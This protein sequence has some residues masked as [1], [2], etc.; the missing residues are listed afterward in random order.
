[1]GR[2]LCQL[3]YTIV[4]YGEKHPGFA[5]KND[6]DVYSLPE[7]GDSN[8]MDTKNGELTANSNDNS[9]VLFIEE[10][11][12][13]AKK[14]AQINT[15]LTES[16]R[17]FSLRDVSKA[18]ERSNSFSIMV[19][20]TEQGNLS[21]TLLS[22]NLFNVH[23][24]FLHST[25]NQTACLLN[26]LKNFEPA[27]RCQGNIRGASKRKSRRPVLWER[28]EGKKTDS[29]SFQAAT[30]E[31]C[32][33]LHEE[34]SWQSFTEGE[35]CFSKS[36]E[37]VPQN[38]QSHSKKDSAAPN[39]PTDFTLPPRFIQKGQDV[40]K[41]SGDHSYRETHFNS[42]TAIPKS[43]TCNYKGN[44]SSKNIPVSTGFCE[45]ISIVLEQMLEN[46]DEEAQHQRTF[47]VAS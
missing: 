45:K 17:Q 8:K 34:G 46:D 24:R 27:Y 14:A 37:N 10:Q 16:H 40:I 29:T 33:N 47:E 25:E 18:R 22:G 1:M 44:L 28:N 9:V 13:D 31:K 21:N 30:N 23:S 42:F 11:Q 43:N 7:L 12:N 19:S 38:S 15:C 39:F 4:N 36:V 3:C 26:S 35:T 2:Y 6:E 5:Y 32:E 41:V 20:N